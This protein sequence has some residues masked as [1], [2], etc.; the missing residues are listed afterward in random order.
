MNIENRKPY[1]PPQ[2]MDFG[3]LANITGI[4]GM[5]VITDCEGSGSNEPAGRLMNSTD[6]N[7][8]T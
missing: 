4:T 2:L 1:E 3:H 5:T 8:A 7:C 6:P